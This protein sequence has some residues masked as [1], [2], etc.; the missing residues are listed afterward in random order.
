MAQVW[1][2]ER[3]DQPAEAARPKRP[4]D[5]RSARAG[6]R[7]IAWLHVVGVAIWALVS[8]VFGALLLAGRTVPVALVI[9][10]V[11]AAS[12]HGLFLL[13]HLYM[14]AAA[15]RRISTQK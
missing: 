11:G 3:Q 1:G 9:A 5:P 8:V 14:A 2:I 4:L 10:S 13:A 12:I 6:H 7:G 15:S